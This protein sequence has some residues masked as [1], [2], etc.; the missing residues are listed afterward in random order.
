MVKKRLLKVKLSSLK[1]SPAIKFSKTSRQIK[2]GR[3]PAEIVRQ[4]KL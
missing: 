1:F 2:D 4:F 3:F